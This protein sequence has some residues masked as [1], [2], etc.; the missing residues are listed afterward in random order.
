MNK[1]VSKNLNEL[2]EQRLTFGQKLSDG[3]AKF[4]GSWFFISFFT[5]VLIAWITVNAAALLGKPFDPYPFILLNLVLSCLAAM[6]A[7]IILMSANREEARDR[8]RAELDF[9]VNKKAELEIES[10]H[11]KI[12]ALAE[13]IKK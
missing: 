6:Q 9:E 10:L 2:H 11:T 13:A 8:L 5:V 1:H 12:D 7:P 4:A 3:L